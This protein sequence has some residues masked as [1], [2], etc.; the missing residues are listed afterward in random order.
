MNEVHKKFMK[1]NETFFL[2]KNMKSISDWGFYEVQRLS[3]LI[4]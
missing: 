3:R 1:C 2:L 4:S